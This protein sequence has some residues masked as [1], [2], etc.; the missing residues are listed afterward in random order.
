MIKYLR[1]RKTDPAIS[2]HTYM[3]IDSIAKFLD[4]S[5]QYV[6]KRC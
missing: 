3:T 6:W 2:K 1:F 4:K 5:Y